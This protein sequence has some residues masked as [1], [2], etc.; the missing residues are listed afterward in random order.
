MKSA[1]LEPMIQ[2]KNKFY[3]IFEVVPVR[4]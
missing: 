2:V 1:F 3:M 4:I